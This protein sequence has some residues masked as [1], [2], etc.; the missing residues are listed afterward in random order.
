METREFITLVGD[1]ATMWPLAALAQQGERQR[2]I[3]VI[4]Y[5]WANGDV[6]RMRIFAKESADLAPDAI[7][8]HT[9]VRH[10]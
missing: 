10:Q 8:A 3:G 1:A 6:N 2:D 4:D 9:H 5:R 7:L